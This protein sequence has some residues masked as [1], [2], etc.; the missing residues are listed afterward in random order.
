MKSGNN[1]T[2][3]LF[4][5]F[6]YG[7]F[8]FIIYLFFCIYASHI[9]IY[10][11]KS[12]LFIFSAD[13]LCD[14]IKQPGAP[15]KYTGGLFSSFYYFPVAGALIT[16]AV[17][18]LSAGSLSY[19]IKFIKGSENL[20]IPFLTGI[21]MFYLQTDYR[22]MLFNNLGILL[23]L[24][25]AC[26]FIKS[27]KS[28]WPLLILP[29]WYFINGGFTWIAYGIYGTWLLAS[30][31]K[32]N[33]IKVFLVVF[34]AAI[35]V[36]LSGEFIFFQPYFILLVYPWSPGI[37]VTDNL[38]FTILSGLIL[39]TP[40]L[41]HLNIRNISKKFRASVFYEKNNM[42]LFPAIT[43]IILLFTAL[44]TTAFLR[45]DGK[46]EDYFR[47]EKLFYS[48]QYD[49]LIRFNLRHPTKNIV[50]IFLNNI[51]LC[52][53]GRLNEMLFNFPQSPDGNTLF[54][55]W[56]LD[57]KGEILRHGGNFY[58]AVGMINE[59]YRWAYEDMVLRG[60]TP[61]GLRMMIKCE[62]INRNYKNAEIYVN[63]LKKTLFYKKEA[64]Q[65]EKMLFNDEA[66]ESHAELGL[67]RKIRPRVDFFTITDDPVIN[68]ERIVATD[69]MYVNR[70]AWEYKMAWHL[71][72]KDLKAI[73]QEWHKL[74]LYGYK[75]VP[76]HLQEAAL[77]MRTL[78]KIEL[79]AQE[80]LKI[81]IETERLYTQ[82]LQTFQLSG[83]DLVKAE[84]SLRRNFGNTFWY[85]LFYK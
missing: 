84:S 44:C 45:Y 3:L 81:D 67:K 55:K 70:N 25:V 52:E 11:E 24:A 65:Y 69:S 75:R 74:D 19:I 46:T 68:I 29:F 2:A 62:L 76:R 6:S 78:I 58:Y 18:L 80:R 15:L 40:F 73:A 23:Q 4:K 51:A 31:F 61:D 60:Y 13:Y 48:R 59:A 22:Y 33:I 47:A 30:G 17:I 38:M 21:L 37:S 56:E 39:F 50:T 20:L 83:Y 8:F 28:N 63:R 26:L 72:N 64:S 1:K 10:Q 77:A 14:F 54:Q 53:T 12:S 49:E 9:F 43:G 5:Y 85:Y 41:C 66:V 7:L 32:K 79:P 27:Q 42:K 71:L 34:L 36:F 16:S 57:I 82:F 35:T